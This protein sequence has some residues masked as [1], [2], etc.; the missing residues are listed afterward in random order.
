[1]KKRIKVV[2]H[3]GALALGVIIS[4][5]VSAQGPTLLDPVSGVESDYVDSVMVAEWTVTNATE[6]A[7][8]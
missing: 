3:L 8:T 1:M 5:S 6:N 2:S 4:I 7:M